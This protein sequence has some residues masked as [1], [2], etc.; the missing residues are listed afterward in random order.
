MKKIARWLIVVAVIVVLALVKVMFFSK[1]KDLKPGGKPRGMVVV[2]VNYH[3]PGASRLE[4]NL[5]ATGVI[6]AFNQVDLVP[7]VAGKVTAIN[8]REGDQVQKGQL[9]VK[10]NDLDLQAQL[11]K[12]RA[13]IKLSE[14]KLGRFK[15]LLEVNGVSREEFEMQENEINTLKADESFM[16][17][18]IAKTSITAPFDGVA[19]LRNV[20]PGSFVNATTPI[21]SLVQLKPVYVEFS[22]PEKYSSLY[23][24]GLKVSFTTEAPGEAVTHTATIHA[25]EPKVDAGTNTIRARAMYEGKA[26]LYPGTFVRVLVNLGAIDSA[27]MVP[28]QCV[29]PTTNGQKVYLVK[30]DSAVEV[31]IRIGVRD[32]KRVQVTGGISAG[33]TIVASGLLAV[34]N[35]S[36]LKLLKPVN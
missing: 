4:N 33:D 18:Q 29:V 23:R 35:G 12:T 21:A 7:E 36:K 11:G 6:G 2:S 16:L 28:T 20:S 1:K 17:A 32:E 22:I 27:L 10:L 14:Q 24:K 3:V 26:T 5:Y 34:K 30:A 13:L 9:M 15:K 25:L 19:G 31:P 8:F